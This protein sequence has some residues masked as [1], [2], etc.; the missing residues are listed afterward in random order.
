MGITKVGRI[1][2]GEGQP[3]AIVAG[4]CVIEE[5]GIVFQT[6]EKLSKLSMDLGFPLVFKASYDKANRASLD[7]Y[8][9][10]G[11][12]NGLGVLAEVKK[13][14]DVPITT[15]IHSVEEAERCAGRVDLLQVPAFLCRQ[16]DI[17]IAA[18]RTG[19]PVNVKK[20]QFLAPNQV[21]GIVDKVRSGGGGGVM[22][23]ERGT[24]F[25]YGSLVNDFAALPELRKLDCPIVFDVTHSV[26]TPGSEGSHTGG[27]NEAVPALARCAAA[28][29]F[30]ALFFEVHPDPPKSLCDAQT[31]VPLYRLSELLE[32]ALRF[33]ALA[34]SR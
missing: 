19:L 11:I 30:D 20:G 25:G 9:G 26:Q 7:S 27:R 21:K 29:P 6:A 15:D 23:T 8:R 24:S 18:G 2:I 5:D 28:A 17:L 13:R 33:G 32:D 1:S 16:T 12:E 10:P 34:R 14:Y 22:I 4:P 31:M 3:L